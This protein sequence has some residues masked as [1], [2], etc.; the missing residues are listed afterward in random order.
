MQPSRRYPDTPEASIR[1]RGFF[2]EG[3]FNSITI[4]VNSAWA[5]DVGTTG[6]EIPLW[7]RG[8]AEI[9]PQIYPYPDIAFLT[10]AEGDTDNPQ[11]S[12]ECLDADN[13]Y[14]YTDPVAAAATTN[15]DR[16]SARNGIDYSLLG[17]AACTQKLI[18]VTE[19]ANV[20]NVRRNAAQ[21]ILPGL[22]RFTLRVAPSPV[23]T[24]LNVERGDKPIFAGISSITLM[25]APVGKIPNEFETLINGL[26]KKTEPNNPIDTLNPDVVYPRTKDNRKSGPKTYTDVLEA[27]DAVIANQ[28]KENLEALKKKLEAL[29]GSS[30]HKFV[31]DLSDF[32]SSDGDGLLKELGKTIKGAS[33]LIKAANDLDTEECKR[34]AARA[35]DT[36]RHRKMLCLQ[37]LRQAESDA[38]RWIDQYSDDKDKLKEELPKE[39]ERFV[40]E[41][42]RE[43]FS[44]ASKGLGDI[45]G[46]VAT[47]RAVVGDWQSDVTNTMTHARARVSAYRRGYDRNKPWSPNRLRT[48]LEKLSSELDV[49]EKEAKSAIFGARTRLATELDKATSVLS[50]RLTTMMM[51]VINTQSEAKRNAVELKKSV[52]NIFRG[53]KQKIADLPSEAK[54]LVQL[55]R[56]ESLIEKIKDEEKKKKAKEIYANLTSNIKQLDIDKKKADTI[57]AIGNFNEEIGENFRKAEDAAKAGCRRS[58][59]RD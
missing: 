46:G 14:F 24:R 57:S 40:K 18:D 25:R 19:K 26:E 29:R 55:E 6:W 37:M 4:H 7:N 13:L 35:A 33:S 1:S 28:T 17:N 45:R 3:R 56:L 52:D 42:T 31:N 36:I 27:Y 50:G 39:V 2:E 47:A 9:R 5:R 20:G 30:D 10:A 8:E 38:V 34:I 44:Q 12:H 22:R 15:T 23:R 58:E 32:L 21:R 11:A 53:A 41:N 43:L 49:V 48:A 59:D 54:I 51:Y 16:W